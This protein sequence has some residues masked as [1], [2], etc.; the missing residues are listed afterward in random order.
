VIPA[1]PTGAACKVNWPLAGLTVLCL[2]VL[3]GIG[4]FRLKIDTDIIS[5]LPGKDPVVAD[6][7][8]VIRH[9]PNQDRVVID[10]GLDSAS[11]ELLVQADALV[12]KRLRASGLFSTVGMA[13]VQEQMGKLVASVWERLPELFTPDQLERNIAPQLTREKIHLKLEKDLST[14]YGMEGIGQEGRITHDPLG[15]SGPVLARLAELAPTRRVKLYAGKLLSL[16]ERHLL[17]FARPAGPGTD[18]RLG[19]KIAALMNQISREL[20]RIYL[21][22]GHRF[23]LT[24]MGAYRAA[25]DNETAAR[26]DIQRAILLSTIGIALLLLFAFPRPLMGLLALLPAAAGTIM[27]LFVCSLIYGAL[28]ILTIGFGGAIISITVDQGIAYLLFLDRPHETEGRRAASEVR[29][30]ALLSTLTTMGAFFILLFSGFPI[31][32]QIGV[33]AAMGIGFSFLFVHSV[34]PRILP[35][36]PGARR[37]GPLP[38]QRLVNG[39]GHLGAWR[40]RWVFAAGLCLILGLFARPDFHVDLRSMSYLSAGTRAAESRIRETWGDIFSNLYLM[41]EAENPGKLQQR[42]DRLLSLLET[43]RASGGIRSGFLPGLIYPGKRRAD[44]N[45]HAWKTFWTEKRKEETERIVREESAALGFSADAFSPFFAA[46]GQ[47]L[48]VYRPI[49]E[50]QYEILGIFRL[51]GQD[52]WI[53]FSTLTRGKRYDPRAFFS[54]VHSIGDVKFLDPRYFS[55]RLGALLSR[56]FLKMFFM[57]GCSVMGLLLLFLRD[58]RLTLLALAPIGFSLITTLGT[59]RLMGHPLDFPALM[60]S[61]VVIGMGVDYSIF[62]IRSRQRYG[63]V[64]HEAVGLMRMAVFL[65]ATSTLIGFGS[66][67]LATQ[68]LLRSAGLPSFLGIAYALLATFLLLGDVPERP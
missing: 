48:P 14:L 17:L 18:T 5:A 63:D 16:D 50:A 20:D 11:P 29:S 45:F 40:Y 8:A 54:R 6:A 57:V 55:K 32:G 26:A 67:S 13:P 3:A 22:A 59:L 2:A 34:F 39:I 25:I 1:P 36:M 49:P 43:E 68:P 15:L 30:A 42:G 12:E 24:P 44:R 9:H 4:M 27:S 7:R 46:L 65:A 66:L 47:K 28:S 62:F 38:L 60:L 10:L 31:L 41:A 52:G 23:T 56:T 51:P 58:V 53:Q 61:I 21:P 19:R 37:K 33:F 64:R 35:R